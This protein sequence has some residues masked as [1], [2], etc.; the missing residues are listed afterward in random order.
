MCA[1]SRDEGRRFVFEGVRSF[2]LEECWI[3]EQCLPLNLDQDDGHSFHAALTEV[4]RR[5]RVRELPVLPCWGAPTGG[6]AARKR[7][8]P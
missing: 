6:R 1:D 3:R 7:R 8:R 5:A 4:R 2:Q